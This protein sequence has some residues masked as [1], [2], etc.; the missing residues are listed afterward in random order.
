MDFRYRLVASG[1]RRN[2]ACSD[3]PL[4]MESM[5]AQVDSN[6]LIEALKK[7]AGDSG[8]NLGDD[9]M[10]VFDPRT[11]QAAYVP[12]KTGGNGWKEVA[13]IVLPILVPMLVS[14]WGFA[15]SVNTRLTTLETNFTWLRSGNK[16]GSG[17][18][19]TEF[20]TP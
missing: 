19:A 13:K 3:C 20:R 17:N 12:I 10:I 11:R 8:N 1:N 16:M 4:W 7:R 2:M 18:S 14:F 15:W 5:A 9:R 6:D